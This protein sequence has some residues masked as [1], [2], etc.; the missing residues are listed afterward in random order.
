MLIFAFGRAGTPRASRRA[1]TGRV[2]SS[3][4]RVASPQET[5]VSTSART[6]CSCRTT[7]FELLLPDL[8]F[9]DGGEDLFV[10]EFRFHL[11]GERLLQKGKDG[12]VRLQLHVHRDEDLEDLFEVGHPGARPGAAE[13][14][15]HAVLPAA[16]PAGHVVGLH[17]LGAAPPLVR[18]GM[19]DARVAELGPE[20]ARVL[21]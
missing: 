20:G 16:E 9:E 21:H 2:P 4:K 18:R 1:R 14:E 6:G 8:E 17:L 5:T 15:G 3:A 10:P 11:S 13:F 7:C 19:L 12:I